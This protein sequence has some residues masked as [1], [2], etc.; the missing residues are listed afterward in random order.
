MNTRNRHVLH[1]MIVMTHVIPKEETHSLTHSSHLILY[2]LWTQTSNPW[3]PSKREKVYTRSIAPFFT[4]G[5][6][7]PQQQE[8]ITM[9]EHPMCKSGT[10]TVTCTKFSGNKYSLCYPPSTKGIKQA[11]IR[12]R[13]RRQQQRLLTYLLACLLAYWLTTLKERRSRAE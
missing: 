1:H 7:Q 13:R 4:W 10:N 2:Y 5:S 3:N 12:R 8:R 6:Q 11:S 9:Y